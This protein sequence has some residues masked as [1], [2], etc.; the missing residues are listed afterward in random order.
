MKLFLTSSCV[1]ENIQQDF[2]NE[3]GK[4]PKESICYFIPTATD[5]E[6]EKFY[7]CKSM[8]DLAVLGFNPIWYSLKFKTEELIEEELS[9]ADIIWVGGGNT[10]YLLDI[11]RQT[12]FLEVITDLVKNKYIAYGG[13]S[14]GTLLTAQNI[15]SAG[16]GPHGDT[17]NVGIT[18]LVALDLINF[19]PVV[20]YTDAYIETIKKN[21]RTEDSV[22]TIPD[23]GMIVIDNDEIKLAGGAKLYSD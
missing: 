7:T 20:H 1:N 12:G 15:S 16:W 17:N 23:G 2:L 10:F 13:I 3:F 9:D 11:A 4:D 19:I 14:A 5:P 18:D 21:K 6:K 8:D 22:Y